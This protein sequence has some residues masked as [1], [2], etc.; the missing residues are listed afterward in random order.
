MCR[1]TKG[2]HR[3]DRCFLSKVVC[4][5]KKLFNYSTGR[6]YENAAKY[7]GAFCYRAVGQN[8]FKGFTN[9]LEKAVDV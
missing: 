4:N 9:V 2:P 8:Q 5:K 3:K 1:T 7:L 6:K